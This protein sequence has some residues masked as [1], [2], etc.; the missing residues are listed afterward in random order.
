LLTSVAISFSIITL[1]AVLIVVS[2]VATSTV[3]SL[4]SL[5]EVFPALQISNITGFLVMF[6][7]P[8]FLVLVVTTF[9]YKLLPAKKVSLRH[10]FQGAFF[11]AVFLEVARHLFTLYVL[12]A[13]AQYGAVYG[14]LSTFVIFLLWVF[15]SACIF[16]IGAEIVRNLEVSRSRP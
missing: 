8:V 12:T 15:Y 11:T 13:A 16:L 4:Q 7:I 10:A 9:L 14:P 6:V 1:I 2:F 3:Q 5:F